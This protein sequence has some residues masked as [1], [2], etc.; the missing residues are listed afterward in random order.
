[1][2]QELAE[3][4]TP[5]SAAFLKIGFRCPTCGGDA[6]LT[7]DGVRCSVC[8][9]L[10][11]AINGALDFMGPY[12]RCP[13]PEA[14]RISAAAEHIRQALD[15]PIAARAEVYA[16]VAAS[17]DRT[18]IP[19][20]DAEIAALPSRFGDANFTG[21]ASETSPATYARHMTLLA[22]FGPPR[23]P[24]GTRV[25]RSIR[26]RADRDLSKADG[27]AYAWFR[28]PVRTRLEWS[29][30]LAYWFRKPAAYLPVGLTAG[31]ELSIPLAI[32]T[33][34]RAGTWTLSI[35]PVVGGRPRIAE[36]YDAELHVGGE[37]EPDH[38]TGAFYPDYGEDHLAANRMLQTYLRDSAPSVL[39][40]VAAGVNPHLALL[41]DDGH[42]V[43][44]SDVCA[45]QMRLGAIHCRY[46][47]PH[48]VDRLGYAA[49]DAFNPPFPPAKFDGVA[50]F[51]ALHH[52]PKPIAFLTE[53][54]R[55]VRS[56][57]FV[58]ALCEPAD[59]ES[60]G[61][62]YLRDLQAGINEQVFTQAEYLWMIEQ[63][64]LVPNEVRNDGGS[65]KVIARLP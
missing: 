37:P 26:L 8:S 29:K 2:N 27:V 40:E 33:P 36:R 13:E 52:F 16:T 31:R 61:A 18:G 43:I 50:M 64:G 3:P 59:P 57:G 15:L 28:R 22:T 30:R 6:H 63:A 32:E 41:A 10:Y 44:A 49:F 38:T 7:T 9:A 48:L 35:F 46:K 39:L 23:V 12:T 4:R 65:L 1:M 47:M 5:L 51:S 25:Y 56:G 62:D 42:T 20:L 60:V 14:G 58:A 53:L 24:A 45:N 34:D 55:M 54:A 21:V 17:L 11:P 19:H